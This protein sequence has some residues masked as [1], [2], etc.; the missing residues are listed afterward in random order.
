MHATIVQLYLILSC[1]PGSVSRSI[2]QS[3]IITEALHKGLCSKQLKELCSIY[4]L[5]SGRANSVFIQGHDLSKQLEHLET[6]YFLIKNRLIVQHPRVLK[7]VIQ[8][9]RRVA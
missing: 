3:I 5:S 6:R 4:S 2:G 8:N 7:T 1:F 9:A